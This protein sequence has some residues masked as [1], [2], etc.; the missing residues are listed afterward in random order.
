MHAN[1]THT[2]I[3]M[4]RWE[5]ARAGIEGV[6]EMLRGRE[7]FNSAIWMAPID[8]HGLMI[9]VWED[10][11]RAMDAAVPPGFSPAPGVT[12]ERVE[13]RAIIDEA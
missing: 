4:A 7:G 6:K 12:V 3:D 13:T 10:E 9:S 5:E 2:A 1:V 11:A 8:G